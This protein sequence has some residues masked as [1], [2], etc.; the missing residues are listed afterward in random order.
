MIGLPE[1]WAITTGSSNIIVAVVDN[2]IRFDHPALTAN[3]R[4]DGYDFVSQT[5]ATFCAGGRPVTPETETATTPIPR[6]R[7]TTMCWEADAWE[8]GPSSEDTAFTP[9][10]PSAPWATTA[11][12]SSE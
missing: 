6:F 11:C 9:R 10:V 3:L 4:S 12:Q 8:G 5:N 1:A 2:G 7:W